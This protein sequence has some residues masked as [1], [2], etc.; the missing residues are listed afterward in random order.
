MTEKLHTKFEASQRLNLEKVKD[1]HIIK[2]KIKQRGIKRG[3][4]TTFIGK[5]IN[6]ML[7]TELNI[8][9][10]IKKTERFAGC[11]YRSICRD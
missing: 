3:Q 10:A 8:K 9:C 7:E 1:E 4:T 11:Y 2:G 5:L 6:G